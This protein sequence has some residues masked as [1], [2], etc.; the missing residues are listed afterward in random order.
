VILVQ[1]LFSALQVPALARLLE[2]R[3]GDQPVE[4]V[5]RDGCFRGHRRHRFQALQLLDGLLLDVLRHLGLFDLLL[6]IVDLVAFFVLA[7]QFLLDRLHLL[8][9]VVL[10]LRLLHLLL[11]ARLDA[12]VHLQLV[13]FDFQNPG[14]AVQPLDG[15][16]DLEEVLLLVHADEQVR[17]DRVGQLARILHAHGRDHRVVVQVVRQLHVLLEQRHDAAHRALGLAVGFARLRQHLHDDAV[18][19]LVFLPLDGAR[20]VD[21]FDQ[22]L[23]VAVGQL[24]ALDHVRHA[25]H[26]VDVFRTRIV[27]RRV[28][29]RRQENALV[30]QQRMLE[31]AGGARPADHERHHHVREDDDVAQRDDREGFVHF[32]RGL[33]H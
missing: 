23:D 16:D 24:Q 9:E 30:L 28:V 27:D 3:H 14:D 33:R 12:A 11:D 19:P 17:G 13:D 29:L 10:F 26:R 5:A 7:A 20:A 15:G 31:G 6:Q 2:P 4:V 32:Q 18:K 1:D 8:V 22:D 25:A 21:A